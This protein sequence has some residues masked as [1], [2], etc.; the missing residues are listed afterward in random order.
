[1]VSIVAVAGAVAGWCREAAFLS[2]TKHR[3]LAGRD[4]VV[5]AMGGG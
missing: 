2:V 4:R 3:D 5:A 1:M